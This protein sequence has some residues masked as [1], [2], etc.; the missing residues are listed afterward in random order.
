MARIL[1]DRDVK[2][3]IGTLIQGAD[4]KFL[5]PNG[6][7]LRLG[8]HV[9]FLSTGEDKKL[10]EGLFLKVAPGETVLISSME[11]L[12]FTKKSVEKA[13][14][15]AMLMGLITPTTTMMREGISQAATKIDAGFRG[16]LN[17][18]LR[19]G[20]TKDLIL[21]FGE[22]I[23][24]LTLFLLDENE[25]PDVAYGERPGDRYQD[26]AAIVR[27]R[28][29]IPVDIPK[30]KLIAS[31]IEKLDPKKHLREAGYPFDHIGTE[32]T[33]LHGKF[34]VVSSDVKLLH[35][36]FEKLDKTLSGKI[37]TE[38]KSLLEK[39]NEVSTSVLQKVEILLNERMLRSFGVLVG[40]ASLGIA[41]YKAI[42]ASAPNSTQVYVFLGV[43]ALALIFAVLVPKIGRR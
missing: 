36:E 38:T 20:S 42:L 21:Q 13:F 8:T 29:T 22:P 28:R 19:N 5:N 30:K 3:V 39:I 17:W 33:T 43:A 16:V 6:I 18:S 2:R 10:D 4:E 37:E 41:G 12:D 1:P 25:R 32:L 35:D 40:I 11:E 24:K 23:F 34:E 27:S 7:E 14:P 15:K 31:S 9:R 26:S